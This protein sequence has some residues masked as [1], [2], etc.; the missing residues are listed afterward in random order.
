[1]PKLHRNMNRK[2][3]NGGGKGNLRNGNER[4]VREAAEGDLE[5]FGE[6]YSIYVERMHRYVF[7]QVKNRAMAEDITEE[8]FIK[9]WKAIGSCKGKEQTFSAW[10][11]RIAHNEAIDNLRKIGRRQFVDI[12]TLD[13]VDD[14][15]PEYEEILDRQQ[16]LGLMDGLPENQ[17]QVLILK[18][19]E[20]LAN[21]EIGRI[22]SRSQGA[23]RILQM[24]GL[25]TLRE[26]LKIEQQGNET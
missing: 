2:A 14:S 6:L 16:V 3:I 17:Q 26:K 1:M 4:L 15:G 23:V 10:L 22:M 18:F 11:Y 13:I 19:I 12:E 9:A 21:N 20:G 5:A 8:V 25:S 7:Y 24:R